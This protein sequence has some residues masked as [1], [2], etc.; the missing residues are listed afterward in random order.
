MK[1]NYFSLRFPSGLEFDRNLLEFELISLLAFTKE[2]L[3]LLR[4]ILEN[5]FLSFILTDVKSRCLKIWLQSMVK[6]TLS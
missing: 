3:R 2:T 6:Q 5:Y 1:F 4:L